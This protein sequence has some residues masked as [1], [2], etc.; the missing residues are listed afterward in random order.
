MGFVFIAERGVTKVLRPF[1]VAAL[2]VLFNARNCHLVVQNHDDMALFQRLR[3]GDTART[4]LIKGSG[5]D[6]KDFLLRG[7]NPRSIP[8]ETLNKWNENGEVKWLG[9]RSDIADIWAGSHMAVLPSY[10]EGL[11]KSLLEAAACGRAMIATD[12]PGCRELV[13]HRENGLLVPVRDGAA[14]AAAIERLAGDKSLR[15]AL[16]TQ[17]RRDIEESYAAEVIAAQVG[18]LYQNL[19]DDGN[20]HKGRL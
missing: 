3:L 6:L 2:R 9:H 12:V 19:M 15:R 17:A 1:L 5:V 4:H 18:T 13:R 8:E 10:R 16:G 11:P 7:A 14:L 20:N